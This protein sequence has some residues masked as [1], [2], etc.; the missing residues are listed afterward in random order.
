VTTCGG[1]PPRPARGERAGEGPRS[2]A[3]NRQLVRLRA[4]DVNT[5]SSRARPPARNVR[6]RVLDRRP[7]RAP[8]RV[9]ARRI[10]R[11]RAQRLRH[12]VSHLGRTGVVALWS[13]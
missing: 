4:P 2:S 8:R 10:A 1:P 13:R 11:Q 9:R 6:A 7:R 12:R 5:I 3:A